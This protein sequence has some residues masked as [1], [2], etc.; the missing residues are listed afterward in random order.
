MDKVCPICNNKRHIFKEGKGWVR[1][2]CLDQLRASRVMEKSNF[3]NSLWEIDSNEY[4]PG[5]NLDRKK[6]G[7][8]IIAMVKNY[9]KQPIYIYSESVDKDVAAAII[10]RYTVILHPEVKTVAY[11]TMEQLVQMQFGKTFE[12]LPNVDPWKADISV[13]SIGR[14]MTNNAHRSTFY[15]LLYDRVLAGKLTIVCSFVNKNRIVQVYHK[16]IDSLMEK[17][18]VF[19][20]C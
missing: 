15:S 7:Q 14:E 13:I 1:C 16:A 9:D 12:S 17:N 11:V 19:Y 20:S 10:C 3:P 4:V 8:G 5:E 2:E 18:F 6:L